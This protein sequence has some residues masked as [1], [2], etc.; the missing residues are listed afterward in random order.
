M[1]LEFHLQKKKTEGPANIIEYL[2]LT[3]D[4]INKRIKDILLLPKIKLKE[5]QSICGL[6]AFCVKA[7]PAGRAFSRRL[8]MATSRASKPHHFIR[9]TSGMKND[10]L[11]WKLFLENFNGVS[12]IL[13]TNWESNVDLKLYTDSA[14]GRGKG[15]TAYFK[16]KWAYLEWPSEWQGTDILRDMT[17][18]EI[19][20]IALAIYL[21]F[22][23]FYLKNILFYSDNLA[24]VTVL[25]SK[26]CKSDRVMSC[27]L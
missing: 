18:L 23:H 8:Y 13:D 20:P 21:W 9:I 10:L 15:C 27:G 4:T 17:F 22:D 1:K 25:N 24:V 19:L 14:G 7:I 11:M 6:L 3:I 12:Y 26:S 16:G 2:G 5:L